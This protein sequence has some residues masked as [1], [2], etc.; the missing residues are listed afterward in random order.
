MKIN[1]RGECQTLPLA[2][3]M[4]TTYA[5]YGGTRADARQAKQSNCTA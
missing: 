1:V 3:A 2:P 5:H 4:T